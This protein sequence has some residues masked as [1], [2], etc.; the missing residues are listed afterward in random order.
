MEF[1]TNVIT[2]SALLEFAKG[3]DGWEKR[4]CYAKL[5]QYLYGGGRDRVCLLYGLRRT[6]KTTLLRQA[7]LNMSEEQRQRGTKHWHHR[8]PCTGDQGVPAS[9]RPHCQLSHRD[10]PFKESVAGI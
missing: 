8:S 10:V 2:G 3:V 4:D 7:I 6:G 5:E 1:E 9:P